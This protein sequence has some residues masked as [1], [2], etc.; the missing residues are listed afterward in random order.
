MGN[1]EKKKSFTENKEK[2]WHTFMCYQIRNS[3]T[4]ILNRGGGEENGGGR[5]IKWKNTQKNKS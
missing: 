5:Y 3:K 1:Q 4:S 2:N